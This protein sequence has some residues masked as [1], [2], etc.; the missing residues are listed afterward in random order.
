MRR[1]GGEWEEQQEAEGQVR[2]QWMVAGEGGGGEAAQ[3]A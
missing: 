2:E 1:V 3:G